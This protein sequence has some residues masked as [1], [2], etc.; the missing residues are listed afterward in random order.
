M[1]ARINQR[2]NR[3]AYMQHKGYYKQHVGFALRIGKTQMQ[4]FGGSFEL[5]SNLRGSLCSMPGC[6]RIHRHRVYPVILNLGPILRQWAFRFYL[7]PCHRVSRG[8]ALPYNFIKYVR[9]C[10]ILINLQR[11][12]SEIIYES[13]D[14]K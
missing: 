2:G 12:L 5:L 14:S 11:I 6:L 1:P 10:V 3:Q 13:D 9:I 7:S 4:Y 8:H